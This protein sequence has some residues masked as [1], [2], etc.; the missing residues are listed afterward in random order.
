MKERRK[1]SSKS[2]LGSS[3][4]LTSSLR[5]ST[6]IPSN[7]QGQLTPIPILENEQLINKFPSFLPTVKEE[8]SPERKDLSQ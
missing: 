1:R 7:N 4:S 6:I 8:T 5:E 3:R 2:N